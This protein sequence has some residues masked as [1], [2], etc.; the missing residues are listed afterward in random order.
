MNPWINIALALVP[1]VR[2]LITALIGLRKKYPQLTPEEI[3]KVIADITAQADTAFDDVL[4]RI[5][6]DQPK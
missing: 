5:A 6:A 4:A 1:E 2:A 3:Q